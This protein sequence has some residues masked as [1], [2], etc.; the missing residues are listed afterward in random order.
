MVKRGNIATDYLGWIVLAA[1]ALVLGVIAIIV[2]KKG[3]EETI[4]QIFK[5]LR[6]G[7]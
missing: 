4:S 5:F 2:F 6:F 3:G 1:L 7:K